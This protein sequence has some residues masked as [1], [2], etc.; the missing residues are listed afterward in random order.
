MLVLWPKRGIVDQKSGRKLQTFQLTTLYLW[1]HQFGSQKCFTFLLHLVRVACQATTFKNQTITIR[2]VKFDMIVAQNEQLR[3][4]YRNKLDA[5][6]SNKANDRG[7]RA[8]V[9]KGWYGH[10]D[11]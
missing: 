10:D 4:E 9:N 8:A 11:L 7:A 2:P 1:I 5:T 6:F 3:N